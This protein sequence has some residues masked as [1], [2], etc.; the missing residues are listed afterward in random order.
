MDVSLQLSLLLW[1]SIWMSLDFYGYPCI[2]LLWIFYPGYISTA[3]LILIG[4]ME[5]KGNLSKIQG[6]FRFFIP[7]KS[8][9]VCVSFSYFK[10]VLGHVDFILYTAYFINCELVPFKFKLIHKNKASTLN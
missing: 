1:I 2:D 9:F 7:I 3:P 10:M 5:R 6:F 4:L 8:V